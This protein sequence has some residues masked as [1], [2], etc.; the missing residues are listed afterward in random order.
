MKFDEIIV[1]IGEFGRY[2]QRT[3]F[4][5]SLV[6]IACAMHGLTH[7]S[8]Q[9]RG[10]HMSIVNVLF[11]RDG[12]LNDNNFFG[13]AVDEDQ[14]RSLLGGQDV[15][16]DCGPRNFRSTGKIAIEGPGGIADFTKGV[17]DNAENRIMAPWESDHWCVVPELQNEDCAR[18]PELS[19]EKCDAAKKDASIPPQSST[20]R[21]YKYDNCLRYNLTGI[22]PFYPGIDTSDYT[23]DTLQCDYGW[24]YDTSQYKSTITNEFDLVCSKSSVTNLM[25]SIYFAGLF[26]GSL[27]FG[28]YRIATE[29]V[30]PSF[31]TV[32]GIGKSFFWAFGFMLLALLAFLIRDWFILQLVL[33]VPL[34]FPF[35]LITILKESPRWLM[36]KGRFDEAEV[37]IKDIARVNK[38]KVPEPLFE[39][40]EK[41][42]ILETNQAKQATILDLFRT[43]TLRWRTL[44]MM[45][46]W[47]VNSIVYYGL[48]LS[49]SDLG[50][51]DYVAFFLSGL[52][53]VPAY[54]WCM[55]GIEWL[56]RKPNL[57]G[58]FI[59]GGIACL[60]TLF[61]E[62]GTA[63]TAIAMLGKFCIT[64]TFSI[65]FI[66]SAEMFPTVVRSAGVGI[67]S[68]ASR[69]GGIL[70]PLI[71]ILG[72]Y[73]P[74][75]PLIIFG[76]SAII[77]GLLA[78]LFPETKGKTLP[79]TIEEGEMFGKKQQ[80][81]KK[82]AS[83]IKVAAVSGNINPAFESEKTS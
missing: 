18:W 71:L 72:E 3:F 9:W 27:V 46:S 52:V 25:A 22:P 36:A 44:N 29:L 66:Y 20:T 70:A 28:C 2:Q 16:W 45:F 19:P 73:W 33:T 7:V 82:A 59:L 1:E 47:F 15:R 48:S 50:S 41:I 4:L 77:A 80:Y 53:E 83:E 6:G 38:T 31:R 23:N 64:G 57:C 35:F 76:S 11:K 37:I 67:S 21:S 14:I 61:F 32:T 8:I 12:E 81:S 62:P 17:K 78:L 51:N 26:V 58:L 24:M 54:L 5:V 55:F 63:M 40:S 43:P 10:R 75:L 30:G 56:G 34:I 68:M 79:E 13:S 49:T 60:C 39:E 42:E 74:P 65:V 69:V